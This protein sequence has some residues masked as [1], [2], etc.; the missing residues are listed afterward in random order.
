MIFDM[1]N[2]FIDYQEGYKDFSNQTI[3]KREN[4][5][6]FNLYN[7]LFFKK[8]N[9][10]KRRDVIK[11]IISDINFEIEKDPCISV[12]PYQT[13]PDLHKKYKE[14]DHWI[15]LINSIGIAIEKYINNN[16]KC[17]NVISLKCEACWANVSKPESNYSIHN[18]QT[19]LSVVYFIKNPSKI[20]GT[21]F[22]FDESEIIL[23]SEENSLVI[24]DP[25][26]QHC[27]VSPPPQ[28]SSLNPRYSIVFDYSFFY[29]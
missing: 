26:L 17:S 3:L 9:I 6:F 20:Y 10:I 22:K 7:H 18:H 8:N 5:Y 13:Q 16:P 21:L 11:K 28:V 25:K 14:F 4:G 24:F 27:I 15:E 19:D 1:D 23:C 29:E 2:N 12:P